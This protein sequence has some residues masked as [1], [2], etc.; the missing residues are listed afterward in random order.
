MMGSHECMAAC[1]PTDNRAHTCVQFNSARVDTRSFL[2]S[3]V[4]KRQSLSPKERCN[5]VSA[6]HRPHAAAQHSTFMRKK[7]T[8]TR[9]VDTHRLNHLLTRRHS[10]PAAAAPYGRLTQERKLCCTFIVRQSRG[11]QNYHKLAVVCSTCTQSSTQHTLITTG[12]YPRNPG[13]RTHAPDRHTCTPP[14]SLW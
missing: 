4:W 13:R 5:H 12:C 7:L 6:G 8:S 10:Q 2:P 3:S 14:P 11:Q 9:S 1:R